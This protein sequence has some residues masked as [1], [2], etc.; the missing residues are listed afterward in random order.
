LRLNILTNDV[1]ISQLIK[2]NQSQWTTDIVKNLED[3]EPWFMAADPNHRTWLTLITQRGINA[4]ADW[5]EKIP[6]HFST[7]SFFENEAP[8]DLALSVSF[9][10]IVSVTQKIFT[11]VENQLLAI[12]PKEQKLDVQVQLLRFS[13]DVAFA[14]ALA[15]ARAAEARSGWDARL[16]AKIIDALVDQ[17]ISSEI[18]M[19][20][21]GLGWAESKNIFALVGR[22]P[23]K[24]SALAVAEIHRAASNQ[25]L[26]AISGVRG[27]MLIALIANSENVESIARYFSPRFG[28]GVVV[29]GSLVQSFDK[30]F[31]STREAIAGYGVKS[32]A[33]EN[34]RV[35]AAADLLAERAINSDAL[36]KI[37]LVQIYNNLMRVD[38]DL[39]KTLDNYFASG[40][41][42]E[43]TARKLHIH[44]NTVRYRLKGI[45]QTSGLNPTQPRDAYTLQVALS[46]GKLEDIQ[47]NL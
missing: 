21:A 27:E 44:V 28:A 24:D 14:T 43:A 35:V 11:Y 36:A 41:S 1:I 19:N 3:S 33:V 26:L 38:P 4:F 18:R 5:L 15:Y 34:S 47:S 8:R 10:Q 45:T 42:L 22:K 40:S 2:S 9:E 30:A 32:A 39:I 25:N 6:N 20:A 23:L 37:E 29:Y 16:E 12:L 7:A 46:L 31:Q 13:R 17:E